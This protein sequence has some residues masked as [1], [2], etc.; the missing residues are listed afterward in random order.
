MSIR[1][2]T[3]LF[4]ISFWIINCHAQNIVL[5]RQVIGSYGSSH[6]TSSLIVMDNVGEVAVKTD[7]SA[8]I[9]LSQGFEQSNY[10]IS[11]V[12]IELT[13]PNAFSPDGDGTNDTWI[14]PINDLYA[15]N[16]VVVFNRWGEIIREFSNYNNFDIVWNGTNKNNV[17]VSEGTYFYVIEVNSQNISTSGWVQIVR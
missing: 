16:K 2:K 11:P 17:Q 4:I 14:L 6:Q 15:E 10:S 3:I 8:S 13:P 12:T 7:S 1:Q 5:S 9:I